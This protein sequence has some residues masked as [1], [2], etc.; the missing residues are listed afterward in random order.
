MRG[1]S[2]YGER[3]LKLSVFLIH[4]RANPSLPVWG[5]WIEIFFGYASSPMHTRRSPYGERGLKYS[6][7][8]PAFAALRRSPYGERG[9]KYGRTL[10]RQD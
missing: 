8:L 9:L 7:T 3:G 1:R 6:Q 2:P 10:S 4:H 5:A